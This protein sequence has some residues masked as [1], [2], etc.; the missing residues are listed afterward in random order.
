M[1]GPALLR[2]K[3]ENYA[4]TGSGNVLEVKGVVP[5]S[6]TII[7]FSLLFVLN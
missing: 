3:D 5:S 4:A 2:E 7:T 1:P 6:I